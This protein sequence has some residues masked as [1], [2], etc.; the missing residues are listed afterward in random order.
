MAD[1][2]LDSQTTQGLHDA[3]LRFIDR[4]E[5]LR[6]DLFRFSLRLTK[7]AFDAE[8]LVH[9][10]LIRAFARLGGVQGDVSS[11]RAYLFRILTNLWIDEIRRNRPESAG[12]AEERM[13]DPGDLPDRGQEL[14][15]GAERVL[16]VLPPRERVAFVLKESFD[17]SHLEIANIISSSEGAVKI[18]LHRARRRLA[19]ETPPRRGG[20]RVSRELVDRFVEA[21]RGHD[22]EALRPLLLETVETEVF[23]DGVGVG[24]EFAERQGWLRGSFYHHLPEYEAR[25]EPYPKRF[26]VHEL[27]G[28]AFVAVF[29]D[30]GLGEALEEVWRLEEEDGRVARI[31]DY[32]FSPELLGWVAGELGVAA[33]F[34]GYRF[35]EKM[36]EF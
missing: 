7:N 1:T 23:P 16:A 28:E 31:R 17:L 13:E 35:R 6:P 15:D 10:G 32:C 18:A 5:L 19:E 26:E 24:L 9:D 2:V 34:I 27:D 25:G 14:R 30:H 36:N 33:R 3:W 8:D 20:P 11:P 12:G 21:F 4:V 29:R 22:L